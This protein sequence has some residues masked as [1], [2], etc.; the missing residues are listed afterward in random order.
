MITYTYENAKQNLS[1]LLAKS[2]KEGLVRIK[3]KD[4]E[5]FVVKP[6]KKL[7]SPLDVKG[8]DLGINTVEIIKF[9]HEGRKIK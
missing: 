2:V 5:V 3:N 7:K 6:E 1:T 8:V 9:I 4:G